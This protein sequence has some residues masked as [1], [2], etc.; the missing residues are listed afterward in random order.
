M[1]CTQPSNK[2]SS[3]SAARNWK[4]RTDLKLTLKLSEASAV[5][6]EWQEIIKS[7]IDV[8]KAMLSDDLADK[9]N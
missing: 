9:S 3:K 4:K 1:Q 2:K 7:S 5:P 6:E 8:F